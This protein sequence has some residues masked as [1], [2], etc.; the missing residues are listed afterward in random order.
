MKTF[1]PFCYEKENLVWRFLRSKTQKSIKT[2][3]VFFAHKDI[4]SFQTKGG[5]KVHH[6]PFL[7]HSWL[8]K[9]QKKVPNKL[10][11]VLFF[12]Q[13]KRA[14]FSAP[15]KRQQTFSFPLK[16]YGPNNEKLLSFFSFFDAFCNF[17]SHL[18]SVRRK[19]KRGLKPFSYSLPYQ[20][21]RCL[22]Y[23]F[24]L[25][26]YCVWFVPQRT[27]LHKNTRPKKRS[28]W[29]CMGGSYHDKLHFKQ[30]NPFS[31]S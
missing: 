26:V 4:S 13:S 10:F 7:F 11:V 9:K 19:K 30:R 15:I 25:S 14:L 5:F 18:K 23:Y 1:F 2:F 6:F 24:V 21:L 20:R 12:E 16:K 3:L 8:A 31:S 27:I 28:K 17:C 22:L 29:V